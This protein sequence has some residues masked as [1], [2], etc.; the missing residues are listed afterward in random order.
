MK[1]VNL[2]PVDL[3]VNAEPGA[4]NMGLIGGAAAGV[5][6]LVVV[7]AFFA[8]AR[9]DS[10]KS[11]TGKLGT[12][13]TSA[14]QETQ[15]IEAQIQSVGI[16]VVDSDKQLAESAEKTLVSAYTE[17][18]EFGLMAQELQAIMAGTGGWY[19]TVRASAVGSVDSSGSDGSTVSI[20]G[21]LPTAEQAAS[22]NERVNSTRTLTDA[23]T[24]N[25]T[26]VTLAKKKGRK[27]G[28]YFQFK[29]TA[30]LVDTLKPY[31]STAAK[32]EN[33]VADTGGDPKLSLDPDPVVKPVVRAAA[34]PATPVAPTNSFAVAAAAAA[35]GGN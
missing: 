23:A 31:S 16:P 30:K 5:V 8:M 26:T 18:V 24:V 17:R 28:R 19:T 4:P 22:F 15:S 12:D 25:V 14:Q 6:A 27:V 20:E 32:M 21:F 1:P 2:Y 7:G 3:P 34:K 29:V 33:L 13:T 9:V 11:E 35:R 10:I